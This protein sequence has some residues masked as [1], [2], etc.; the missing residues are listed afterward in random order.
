MRTEQRRGGRSLSYM[1]TLNISLEPLDR[2]V[3]EGGE[4]CGLGY[5]SSP[6]ASIRVE[7]ESA[8]G[9]HDFAGEARQGEW[10]LVPPARRFTLTN[11]RAVTA[12]TILIRFRADAGFFPREGP[13]WHAFRQPRGP[14][15]ADE[16][17]AAPDGERL[18]DAAYFRMQSRLYA[19][20]AEYAESSA[21][22]GS[23][24]S[25]QERTEAELLRSIEATRRQMAE[26]YETNFDM[27]ELASRAGMSTSRFYQVFRRHAGL[28]PHK[29]LTTARLNASLSLLANGSTS[30]AEAA[31]AA[32]YADELYFSRLFKKHMGLT[33]TEFAVRSSRRVVNLCPVF[34]GDVTA[35]GVKPV[36]SL[37]RGWSEETERHLKQ[38]EAAKPDLI[39]TQPVDEPLREALASIAPTEMLQW[40]GWDWK[41]R[42]RYIGNAMQLGTVADRWLQV[43]AEK[44]ANARRQIESKLEGEPFLIVSAFGSRFRVYGAQRKKMQDLFYD[45]LGF[46]RPEAVREIGFLDTERL[47][48]A[49]SLGCDNVLFLLPDSLPEAY[50]RQLEREWRERRKGADLICFLVRHPDPILYSAAFY[51]RLIDETV[52]RLHQWTIH[53][54]SI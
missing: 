45:E 43:F 4:W 46:V 16:F 32:G 24:S 54:K 48:E 3:E 42:L 22:P 18:T 15:W 19:L 35:V 26:Q 8:D 34:E 13:T 17:A 41:D 21:S 39:L 29:Y 47:E 28:S 14:E 5:V 25:S 51:D 53:E 50:E 6:S 27:D 40:K 23:R 44:A 10:F 20:L 9:I 31:H 1:N 30:V 36:L 38:V 7:I 37:G 11:Q 12:E 33:P 2:T 49:A 52:N